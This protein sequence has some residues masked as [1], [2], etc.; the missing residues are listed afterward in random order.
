ME[1]ANSMIIDGCR[2]Y[3]KQLLRP[4]CIVALMQ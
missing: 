3:R 2:G 4:K 1:G